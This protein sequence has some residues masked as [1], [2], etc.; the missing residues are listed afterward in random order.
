[1]SKKRNGPPKR[2]SLKSE[3]AQER[4]TATK[5]MEDA[6]KCRQRIQHIDLRQKKRLCRWLG[7][8]YGIAYELLRNDRAWSEFTGDSLWKGRRQRPRNNTKG[9]D[10]AL[11]WT[12]R[13]LLSD[14]QS[15]NYDR[16]Y[17]YARGLQRF[18]DK[19]VKP[20]KIPALVEKRGGI[21][22]LSKAEA[23]K[24]AKRIGKEKASKAIDLSFLDGLGDSPVSDQDKQP[25]RKQGSR[26]SAAPG[27]S[28]VK[29]GDLPP[30]PLDATANAILKNMDKLRNEV[31]E[32]LRKRAAGEVQFVPRSPPAVIRSSSKPR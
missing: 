21:D 28:A 6:V 17:T 25:E 20:E 1:M 14:G 13:Y 2:P 23:K 31:T 10:K 11:I 9:L 15:E 8:A 18:F 27:K 5:L 29:K 30:F 32:L 16:A 19:G 22:A 4:L 7:R 3:R 24:E 26:H 12:M